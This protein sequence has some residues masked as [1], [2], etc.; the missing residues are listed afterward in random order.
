MLDWPLSQCN[1]VQLILKIAF[2]WKVWSFFSY[3]AHIFRSH[4]FH[5]PD[6]AFIY[7]I[8]CASKKQ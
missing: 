7:V 6:D 8:I 1:R 5:T 2:D 4:S 3:Y